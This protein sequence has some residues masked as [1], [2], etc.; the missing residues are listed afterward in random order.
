I[1]IV[2]FQDQEKVVELKSILKK[3]GQYT[4]RK[5]KV[6][7]DLIPKKIPFDET[8]DYT[9]EIQIVAKE[10]VKIKSWAAIFA[11]QKAEAEADAAAA[12][13]ADA[14]LK[15]AEEVKRREALK[16]ANK[17]K[18][19][20]K[21]EDSKAV[22]EGQQLAM[23][24]KTEEMTVEQQSVVHHRSAAD[25]QSASDQQSDLDQQSDVQKE[26]PSDLES[27][28][29][30]QS[31]VEQQPDL[32][33][34]SEIDQQSA[35]NYDDSQPLETEIQSLEESGGQD[36]EQ[37]VSNSEEIG[38]LSS[39]FNEAVGESSNVEDSVVQLDEAAEISV[40]EDGKNSVSECLS[41][42]VNSYDISQSLSADLSEN[43]SADLSEN[44]MAVL[45]KDESSQSFSGDVAEFYE[46]LNGDMNCIDGSV[47]SSENVKSI[48]ASESLIVDISRSS[49]A[50]AL[51][52]DEDVNTSGR[53]SADG[54]N[55]EISKSSSRSDKN[56]EVS[57]RSV[58]LNIDEQSC[59]HNI[60]VDSISKEETESFK[61]ET[62]SDGT[63]PPELNSLEKEKLPEEII[64]TAVSIVA[65]VLA[66]T[67]V[68][69][70]GISFD[71]D[72]ET[73]CT[74]MTTDLPD[75]E[76]V[77]I[78]IDDRTESYNE[79]LPNED[80]KNSLLEDLSEVSSSNS[81]SGGLETSDESSKSAEDYVADENQEA[82][83][84]DFSDK[85][86]EE[87]TANSDLSE[88]LMV[89]VTAN[90]GNHKEEET[91]NSNL[92]NGRKTKLTA[93]ILSDEHKTKANNVVVSRMLNESLKKA[94][95][96]II[97]TAVR[98]LVDVEKVTL[99]VVKNLEPIVP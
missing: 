45:S 63:V 74:S 3:R 36:Q 2:F 9:V 1:H 79:D 57:E 22:E 65:E 83:T 14:A 15:K 91:A 68:V 52:K 92:T 70:K 48:D 90:S 81:K 62:L 21:E 76:K 56:Y 87:E 61:N 37:R 28:E 99:A 60:R 67:P 51:S 86:K 58:D 17:A 40:S 46:R 23:S 25:Q 71:E 13:E 88:E 41:E 19:V 53:L 78:R 16:R 32:D 43:M 11:A 38:G 10:P 96:D 6:D 49:S 4:M 77:E 69:L 29:D 80:K 89:K 72:T 85:H 98:V 75:S 33:Q 20:K 95:T 64:V 94:S 44:L 50:N 59:L 93:K 12:A 27:P 73:D 66:E 42:N 84:T 34:Q 39:E 26:S 30:R 31:V 54:M 18:L 24:K 47:S 8:K 5:V 97:Q 82:K 35:Q 55:A 7:F